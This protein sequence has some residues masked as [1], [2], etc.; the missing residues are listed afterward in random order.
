M[1]KLLKSSANAPMLNIVDGLMTPSLVRC[2]AH[3]NSA[4]LGSTPLNLSWTR[5][6]SMP[7]RVQWSEDALGGIPFTSFGS[8]VFTLSTS[9]PFSSTPPSTDLKTFHLPMHVQAGG[10]SLV[11]YIKNMVFIFR[12]GNSN[13]FYEPP[14]RRGTIATDPHKYPQQCD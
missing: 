10:T 13:R 2:A 1:K 5:L 12:M 4:R 11:N 9:L 6:G 3:R 14:R 7:R 8:R